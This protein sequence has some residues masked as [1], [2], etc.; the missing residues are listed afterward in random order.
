MAAHE[1][2]SD[3]ATSALVEYS[4]TSVALPAAQVR[5]CLE[6]AD[7]V[8]AQVEAGDLPSGGHP[9]L[10]LA[11]V[12]RVLMVPG[13]SGDK[14][15]MVQGAIYVVHQVASRDTDVYGWQQLRQERELI[16]ALVEAC[17]WRTGMAQQRPRALDAPPE[18]DTTATAAGA[19]EAPPASASHEQV[20]RLLMQG[21]WREFV[22]MLAMVSIQPALDLP[23][24]PWLDGCWLFCGWTDELPE[25]TSS[26]AAPAR[27]ATEALGRIGPVIADD[28]QTVA[29][30]AAA[31]KSGWYLY[32]PRARTSLWLATP[33]HEP[34]ADTPP[35]VRTF[36]FSS[37]G[38]ALQPL[39]ADLRPA[40]RL[41]W[42]ALTP[43]A[44][45]S[46]RRRAEEATT[47]GR[48]NS[49]EGPPRT[50]RPVH[51][52][53]AAS[54]SVLLATQRTL[55]R[56]FG[57]VTYGAT[58]T[59]SS[60]T[61]RSTLTSVR[62]N[63]CEHEDSTEAPV[64]TTASGALMNGDGGAA[65]ADTAAGGAEEAQGEGDAEP[66]SPT[67]R[68]LTNPSI[69][70][71]NTAATTD[72]TTHSLALPPDIASTIA[73]SNCGK[74][75]AVDAVEAH[76]KTCFT[77]DVIPTMTVASLSNSVDVMEHYDRGRVVR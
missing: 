66:H 44:L 52:E 16:T 42:S 13:M 31:G 43:R 5:A 51:L 48:R 9:Q 71:S 65:G 45:A 38:P 17:L 27:I 33:K 63:G 49:V 6:V 67:L 37:A 77:E 36:V 23:L 61:P 10:L 24:Q 21:G 4:T 68:A 69:S 47:P 18:A 46:R 20:V 26:F 50:R 34:D 41:S 30:R 73:C 54:T 39:S 7:L 19:E 28:A 8:A 75:I 25:L 40:S 57:D 35:A 56:E 3:D 15:D 14:D 64:A 72:S 2:E 59:S 1:E 32:D 53:R 74:R 70:T 62:D 12:Q 11:C 58:D 22:A 29:A 60:R 55:M 76:S